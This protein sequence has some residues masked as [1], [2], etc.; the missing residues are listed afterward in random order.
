MFCLDYALAHVWIVVAGIC[1]MYP[2]QGGVGESRV[3][4]GDS[5]RLA[6]GGVR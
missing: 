6:K 5:L 4:V 2:L 1:E 3:R